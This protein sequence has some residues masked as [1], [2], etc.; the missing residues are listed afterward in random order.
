[1]LVETQDYAPQ[2]QRR[3]EDARA[4]QPSSPKVEAAYHRRAP[5]DSGDAEVGR[6]GVD[7][8]GGRWPRGGRNWA[9]QQVRPREEGAGMQDAGSLRWLEGAVE[10]QKRRLREGRPGQR[11][12]RS[13]RLLRMLFCFST[14]HFLMLSFVLSVENG[15]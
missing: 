8:A 7:E 14:D 10:W 15:I 6:N 11:E 3:V 2:E 13:S 1:V 12:G 4:R 5:P 9:A